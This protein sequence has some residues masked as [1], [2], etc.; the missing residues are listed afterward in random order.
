MFKSIEDITYNGLKLSDLLGDPTSK[1]NDEYFLVNEVRG[2]E[3]FT[4]NLQLATVPYMDGAYPVFSSVDPRII[5]VDFTL[6]G[7][8]FEDLRKK[9]DSL[10]RILNTRGEDTVIT[11][12][13][14]P[15]M[16][17][18]GQYS[19]YNHSLEHSRLLQGTIEITCTDPYK[20]SAEIVE[21]FDESVFDI[22]NAGNNSTKPVIR[23]TAKEL[24]TY[25]LITSGDPENNA[26]NMIG[27][28]A[29]DEVEIINEKITKLS[30][31]GS[32]L[33][34]WS[35]AP[36]S[37][38]GGYGL[39]KV[40]GEMTYDDAGIRAG[41]YGTGDKLHGP[42]IYREIDPIQDFE[43]ETT[44]DIISRR[45]IENFRIGINFLDENSNVLGHIGI[46][47]NNRN[48]KRRIPLARYGEYRGSGRQN[49]NLIGDSQANDKAREVTLFYLR[50]RRKGNK[51]SFYIGEWY[52]HKH[53]R[54][55][56]ESYVDVGNEFDGK[57]KYIVFYV[58]T[59][60]DR[61]K[62]SRLR[63][64][65]VNVYELQTY[66]EDQTPY[67]IYPNDEIEFNHETKEILI[68]GEQVKHL[69]DF[70]GGYFD[71]APGINMITTTPEG[72]FDTEITFKEKYL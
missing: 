55:W 38:L 54:S 67:I 19:G 63:M 58:G 8:S 45:E 4:P 71:L 59:Y 48:Y 20:Y 46:K 61:V 30:E 36:L 16:Y 72:A 5:E 37:M 44:F 64:N 49:G 11:F 10:N 7:K 29:D 22:E 18:Y 24:T 70:G 57:L 34:E 6:K 42:A 52:N 12:D 27:K 65:D 56:D 62:P 33:G 51:F 47:D 43:I 39:E 9:V 17:Y 3:L 25:A 13:D 26:Y 53:V 68:N 28:P 2:R 31:T 50:A 1:T 40:D 15:D 32:T 14:E 69:K 21:S 35:E 41:N 60:A 23:L 66:T